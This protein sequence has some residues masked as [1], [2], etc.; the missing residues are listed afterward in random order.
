MYEY[1]VIVN[2]WVYD[3]VFINLVKAQDY[4]DEWNAL[5]N[6]NYYDVYTSNELKRLWRMP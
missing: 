1:I 3:K 5:D 2:G 4:C 6:D